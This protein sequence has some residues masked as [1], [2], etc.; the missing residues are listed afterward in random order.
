MYGLCNTMGIYYGICISKW[1]LWYIRTQFL[2]S[3]FLY[4]TKQSKLFHLTPMTSSLTV[5]RYHNNATTID[6]IACFKRYPAETRYVIEFAV[7]VMSPIW[8]DRVLSFRVGNV[9]PVLL[10]C[11]VTNGMFYLRPS[12]SH[13]DE[14]YHFGWSLRPC[15]DKWHIDENPVL[16]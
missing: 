16:L 2:L 12:M 10:W 14:R 1:S 7:V 8:K 15:N 9:S 11:Y 13:H 3:M 4:S 6:R 5:L